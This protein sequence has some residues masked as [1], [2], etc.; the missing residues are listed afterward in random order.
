MEFIIAVLPGDGIGPEVIGEAVKVL[1]HG[2]GAVRAP[3]RRAIGAIGGNAIDRYGTALPD[4]T[5]EACYNVDAVLFGAAGGP[6][7]GRGR[8]RGAAGA[9]NPQDTSGVRA[10]RQHPSGKVASRALCGEL[11]K[12]GVPRRC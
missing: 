10:V 2:R 1:E 5:L 11:A 12:A 6:K 9:G 8:R 3:V 4:E 7:W